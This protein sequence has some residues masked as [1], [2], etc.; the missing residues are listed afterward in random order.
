MGNLTEDSG[1]GAPPERENANANESSRSRAQRR[2]QADERAV[3]AV[4]MRH[5]KSMNWSQIARE[6]GV[7][8]QGAKN[9]YDR[10]VIA[11]IPRSDVDS[12]REMALAK[13]DLWEQLTLDLYSKTYVT[14]NF[15]K[16][17]TDADGVPVEDWAPKRQLIETLLKIEKERRAICGYSAPNKRVL[18]VVGEDAFDRA[19]RELN[20][21][22]ERLERETQLKDDMERIMAGEPAS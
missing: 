10:G 14:V 1:R 16:L 21:D 7:T 6:L 3:K 20:Q 9:A 11:L 18:E 19:I 17:V 22:A 4:E 13:L 12:Y 5:A 8:P 15:G 2:Y